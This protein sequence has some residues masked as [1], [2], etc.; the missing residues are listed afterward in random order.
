MSRPSLF[1][2]I[3]AGGRTAVRHWRLALVL[4]LTLAAS[5]LLTLPTLSVLTRDF[6]RSPFRDA[7]L[8][9]W[10]ARAVQAWLASRPSEIL[11]VMP[12]L[13]AALAVAGFVQFFLTGG[14]IRLLADAPRRP[15]VR[16]LLSASGAL[17]V[18]SLWALLRLA[19]TGALWWV[20]LVGVPVLALV[21]LPGKTVPPN[22]PLFLLAVAWALVGT[23]AIFFRTLLRFDLA[24]IALARLDAANARG[25]YR[26]AK[27][28]LQRGRFAPLSLLLLWLVAIGALQV[29]FAQL[30]VRLNPHT[31]PGI[32]LLVALSQVS[33]FLATLARLGLWGSLLAWQAGVSPEATAAP[34]LPRA[35]ESAQTLDPGI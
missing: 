28:W 7:L 32:A 22:A 11:A 10:D 19:G 8:R 29:V 26:V 3:A 31:T 12:G 17:L 4:W 2:L 15:V 18:P 27:R 21:K 5:V 1:A 16:R 24:R 20:G 33:V 34:A 13:V 14:A 25:A 9:G 6:D 30:G 35:E 23:L